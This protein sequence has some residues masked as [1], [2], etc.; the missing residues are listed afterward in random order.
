MHVYGFDPGLDTRIEGRRPP[1]NR[2]RRSVDTEAEHHGRAPTSNACAEDV[3]WICGAAPRG[4]SSE[5]KGF[6]GNRDIT[7]LLIIF[8]RRMSSPEGIGCVGASGPDLRK[9]PAP[10]E[11]PE[12]IPCVGKTRIMLATAKRAPG[13]IRGRA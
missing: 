13:L 2:P 12:I 11:K 4:R 7:R 5:A 8:F 9:F 3:P 10:V 6:V 1:D